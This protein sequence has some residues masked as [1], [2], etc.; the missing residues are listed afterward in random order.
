MV[1][2]PR[3]FLI[4]SFGFIFRAYH[5]RARSGVPPMR[6]SAGMQTEAVYI[7]HNMVKRLQSGAQAR[8]SGGDF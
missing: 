2:V 7:F 6:T 5:A 3:L 1:G 8:I 4:D